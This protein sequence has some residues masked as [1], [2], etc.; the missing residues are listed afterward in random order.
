VKKRCSYPLWRMMMHL[1]NHQSYH[2][3]QVTTLL[4]QMGIAAPMVDFL[5]GKDMDYRT[6]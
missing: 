5:Y 2:R 1:I 3:G 4:R 6:T